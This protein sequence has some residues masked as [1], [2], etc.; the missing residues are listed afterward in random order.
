MS[1]LVSVSGWDAKMW[2]R[3]M[4]LASPNH[5]IKYTPRDNDNLNDVRYAL[6][7]KPDRRLFCRLPNL[8]VIFSLG[9]G[10]D[11]ILGMR[12]L[13]DVP[14]V[15]IVDDNLTW[16]MSEWV[17]LQVLL[18]HRQHLSYAAQQGQRV[19]QG[20]EQPTAS[21]V[22]V[23]I[24]GFGVLGR[25]AA[26]VLRTLGF[27]VVAWQRS[28]PRDPTSAT[29]GIEIYAGTAEREAFLAATD[30][31]VGLL[32]HTQQ[33]QG[34]FNRS[35]FCG[36]RADGPLGGPI[37][38]NA[39]RGMTHNEPDVI[40]CLKDKTL[41]AASLDVFAREP[42]DQDSPLWR[43]KNVVITPHV[44]ADSDPASLTKGIAVQIQ[45]YE[46]GQSLQNVVDRNAG[47]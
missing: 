42:L 18:H 1:V 23:G 16:R 3:H 44:A 6:V 32:P 17:T 38:V 34:L 2:A 29:A 10:V 35:V 22:C 5:T 45:R 41:K 11:H 4:A 13:P 28:P 7:W 30:I 26:G 24:A 27:S 47:Y 43:M 19:W 20:R 9:A 40:A 8:E 36:L 21:D 37:F 25:Q 33:T 39:G 46:E 31:L 14:I 15:R 12:P